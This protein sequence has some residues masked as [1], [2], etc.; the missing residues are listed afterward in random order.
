[1]TNATGGS[2]V[3]AGTPSTLMESN[4]GS[5]AFLHDFARTKSFDADYWSALSTSAN[6]TYYDS[7]GY[8]QSAPL[9]QMRFTHDPYT[10]RSLGCLLEVYSNG[11][12]FTQ[13][14]TAGG[15]PSQTNAVTY[16]S[17]TTVNPRNVTSST[18]QRMFSVTTSNAQHYALWSIFQ[19]SDDMCYSAFFKHNSGVIYPVMIIDDG[20]GNGI[21]AQ[22]NLFEG[23]V[24][25]SGNN[26]AATVRK[27]GVQKL[28]NGW[29]RCWVGGSRGG[30]SAWGR[31]T[32]SATATT[33]IGSKW[34]TLETLGI[35]AS[36]MVFGQ[37]L[38]VNM[39]SPS[40]Y[41]ETPSTARNG[42]GLT[43][44]DAKFAEIYNP[45]EGTWL[46]EFNT[47]V[48]TTTGIPGSTSSATGTGCLFEVRSDVGD[49]VS[50]GHYGILPYTYLLTRSYGASQINALSGATLKNGLNKIAIS[51]DSSSLLVSLNGVVY[52]QQGF[53]PT[54]RMKRVTIMQSVEGTNSFNGCISKFG[55]YQR[56]MAAPT[57]AALTA[58]QEC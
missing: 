41:W 40:S 28:P 25:Q 4:F 14:S 17:T 11:N 19:S 32:I 13:S 26:G 56:Y 2:T 38:D 12:V 18:T 55:Y 37:Q 5:P 50:I 6:N 31:M 21:W 52:A 24:V 10:K 15:T 43:L 54:T 7:N 33:T 20:G 22:F 3:L 30:G 45:S 49:V 51:Y 9:N 36:F 8:L 39:Y 1:M 44:K 48:D 47:P 35:G 29:M 42:D 58:P 53:T 57:I 23:T 27:V 16:N 46:M 34:Y